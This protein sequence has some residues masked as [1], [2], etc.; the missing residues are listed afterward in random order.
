LDK[1]SCAIVGTSCNEQEQAA[2]AFTMISAFQRGT[3][4][5]FRHRATLL[6]EKLCKPSSSSSNSSLKSRFF[7]FNNKQETSDKKLRWVASI[8][9]H[10]ALRIA[11]E[12][13]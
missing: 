6:G 5:G 11:K 7:P 3:A 12:A 4:Q 10:G 9:E 2:A 13:V 1:S 8:D